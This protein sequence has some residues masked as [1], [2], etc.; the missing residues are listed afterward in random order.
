MPVPTRR[1]L[2]LFTAGML[3][4]LGPSLGLSWLWAAW[5]AYC[6][7][8]IVLVG[9]DMLHAPPRSKL[10]VELDAPETLYIGEPA[11]A[12][13]ELNF[14]RPIPTPVRVL[15]DLP[16]LFEPAPAYEGECPP[17]GLEVRFDLHAKRRGN[18]TIE[19]VWVR[20]PGP[21]GLIAWNVRREVER[22]IAVA[23]N[24]LPARRMALR[25]AQ[26][27]HFYAGLKIE[28][29]RGDGSEF[30]SLRDFTVGDELRTV[31]W[32]AT[33]R[34]RRVLSQQFRAERNHQV[35]VALDAGRLMSEPFVGDVPR[36]D[37]AVAAALVLGFVSL[38]SG[39]RCGLFA[40]ADRVRAWRKPV[41]GMA[42]FRA[43][44]QQTALIDYSRAE[45]NFT[46]GLTSLTRKLS[47]RSLVVVLTDFVDSIAAELMVENLG[48]LARKH[49][50]VFVTLRDPLLAAWAHAVPQDVLSLNRAIT[51]ASFQRE[52]QTVLRRLE[53][54]GLHTIDA[55][56]D[57]IGPEI[58]NRYLDIKRREQI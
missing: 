14:G 9:V 41:S 38:K 48:R 7:A 12:R 6:A 17:A 58:I 42:G 50:V 31:H 5:L 36:L 20:Y 34:H 13:L 21:L 26:D 56:P 53:R 49:V 25:C 11:A 43:L 47:R 44:Q 45:T 37:R 40:F 18:A 23:P 51:A 29:Y 46:L 8:L 1:T 15:L 35:V 19:S 2:L 55:E 52:R 54:M 57:R 10:R 28:R 32:R 30:D 27:R 24:I 3:L 33:G 16:G 22:R 39:D 4:A